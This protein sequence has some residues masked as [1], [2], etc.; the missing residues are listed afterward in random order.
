MQLLVQVHV[1]AARLLLSTSHVLEVLLHVNA[2]TVRKL[3]I[4]AVQHV[5]VVVAVRA[6]AAVGATTITLDTPRL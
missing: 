4:V 6:E 5:A 3:L 1:D 2:T